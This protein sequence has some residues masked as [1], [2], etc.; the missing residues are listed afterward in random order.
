[1]PA[2]DRVKLNGLPITDDGLR[3]LA[4]SQSVSD[5]EISDT[6]I[7]DAGLANLAR[8]PKLKVPCADRCAI[9]DRGLRT[10][11]GIASLERVSLQDANLTKA[12]VAAVKAARPDLEVWNISPR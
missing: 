11:A 12:A 3:A 5:L 9:T 8:M 6:R 7:T 2:L 1:M 10:L 4:A